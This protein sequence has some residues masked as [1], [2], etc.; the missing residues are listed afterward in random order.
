MFSRSPT[1][2]S[3]PN[4]YAFLPALLWEYFSPLPTQIPFP[5]LFL[6]CLPVSAAFPFSKIQPLL[7]NPRPLLA[8]PDVPLLLSPCSSPS[9]C[10][11]LGRPSL[12][13]CVIVK[14]DGRGGSSRYCHGSC[15]PLPSP[16]PPHTA[17]ISDS[18]VP[19]AGTPEGA[20]PLSFHTRGTGFLPRFM[21]L[22]FADP[23]SAPYPAFSRETLDRSSL[24]QTSELRD[25]TGPFPLSVFLQ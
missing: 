4:P 2:A 11:P 1:P 3:S 6:S 18:C 24:D 23:S 17:A 8:T 13:R 20:H 22:L 9:S 7:P 21:L 10:L 12:V 15:V 16:L 25:W 5:S 19:V 14:G